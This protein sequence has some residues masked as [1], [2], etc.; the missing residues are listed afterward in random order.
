M[1]RQTQA[2]QEDASVSVWSSHR[3]ALTFSCP[4]T[5]CSIF[6]LLSLCRLCLFPS[7]SWCWCSLWQACCPGDVLLVLHVFLFF[8]LRGWTSM[9][10]DWRIDFSHMVAL[11]CDVEN[12]SGETACLFHSAAAA[13]S[14]SSSPFLTLHIVPLSLTLSFLLIFVLRAVGARGLCDRVHG[15]RLQ[16]LNTS[17]KLPVMVRQ[18]ETHSY[19]FSL[20]SVQIFYCRP[21]NPKSVRSKMAATT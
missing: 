16:R 5:L 3:K 19:H 14:S 10:W 21:L 11:L 1:E 6:D 12:T 4:R 18:P 13:R 15:Y 9:E 17:S 7:V 8:V 20:W 2:D